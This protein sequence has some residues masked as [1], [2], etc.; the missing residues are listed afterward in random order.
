[1]LSANSGPCVLIKD[2]TLATTQAMGPY[3]LSTL[4]TPSRWLAYELT[5][6]AVGGHYMVLGT[7]FRWRG[8]GEISVWAHKMPAIN[9]NDS[10]VSGQNSGFC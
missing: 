5:G 10:W 8:C 9:K 1:M 7:G 3:T 2:H 6:L 4:N